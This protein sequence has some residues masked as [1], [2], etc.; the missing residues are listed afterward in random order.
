MIINL[1]NQVSFYHI[2]LRFRETGPYFLHTAG[3]NARR[4]RNSTQR[5]KFY[6]PYEVESNTIY[7]PN[8][9]IDR[10]V[11]NHLVRWDIIVVFMASASKYI[12]FAFSCI[13]RIS[14][15]ICI[16]CI[17]TCAQGCI[18]YILSLILR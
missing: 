13:H 17:D 6:M 18:T 4:S 9:E 15:L 7:K 11:I 8:M 12:W 5:Q 1:L 10:K 2:Y 16:S 3:Y 14:H